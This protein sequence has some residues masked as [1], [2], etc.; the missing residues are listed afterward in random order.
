MMNMI[1]K[2]MISAVH[3]G[4]QMQTLVTRMAMRHRNGR[5]RTIVESM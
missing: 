3:K 4:V 5:E 2:Y 1:I